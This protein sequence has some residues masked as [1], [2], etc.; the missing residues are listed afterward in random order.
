MPTLFSKIVMSLSISFAV[1][2]FFLEYWHDLILRILLFIAGAHDLKTG[3]PS[4]V[5]LLLAVISCIVSIS[6]FN[7]RLIIERDKASVTIE[8]QQRE[9]AE[10]AQKLHFLQAEKELLDRSHKELS[11]ENA[12]LKAELSPLKE[13]EQKR[14][15]FS[16]DL[17][18]AWFV[19]RETPSW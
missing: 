9:N 3:M 6:K 8:K 4:L 14:Q 10:T 15:Q 19:P 16:R 1:A 17:D 11:E 13:A 5:V 18:S 7:Y 2:L 12:R